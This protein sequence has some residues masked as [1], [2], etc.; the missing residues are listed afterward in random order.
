MTLMEIT[1]KSPAYC[2]TPAEGISVVFACAVGELVF[3]GVSVEDIF[4][5]MIS[6]GDGLAAPV[7]GSAEGVAVGVTVFVGDGVALFVGLKSGVSGV[8]LI[9]GVISVGAGV[10]VGTTGIGGLGAGRNNM[11]NNASPTIAEEIIKRMR[12]TFIPL[13]L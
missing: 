12:M 6:V 10:V 3:V 4:A 7:F 11:R 9:S 5:K 2:A 13:F 1:P 8:G